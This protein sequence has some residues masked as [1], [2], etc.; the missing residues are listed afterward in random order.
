MKRFENPIGFHPRHSAFLFDRALLANAEQRGT[1]VAIRVLI[2]ED[3]ALVALDM[4]AA[5]SEA[6]FVV[7]GI[8]DTESDAISETERLNPDVVLM[9]VAL[10]EGSGIAAAH[11]IGNFACIIFVSGNSDQRTLAETGATSAA[12]FVNK[13]FTAESLVRAV[14]AACCGGAGTEVCVALESSAANRQV[15]I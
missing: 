10:R 6:G 8:V 13:P 12:A 14:R 2:V 11:A 3:E 7:E 1:G 9:D 15:G 5:L 4:E